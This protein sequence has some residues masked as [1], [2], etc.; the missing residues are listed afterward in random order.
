M[1]NQCVVIYHIIIMLHIM[2]A[3]NTTQNLI[4]NMEFKLTQYFF[5]KVRKALKF[6]TRLEDAARLDKEQ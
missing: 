6:S 5:R 1:N 4:P 2:I 3:L